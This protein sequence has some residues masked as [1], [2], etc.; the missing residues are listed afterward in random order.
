M[1]DI[2]LQSRNYHANRFCFACIVSEWVWSGYRYMCVN[3]KLLSKK[4]PKTKRKKG[5]CKS[6]T[7]QGARANGLKKWMFLSATIFLVF[8][9][10]ELCSFNLFRYLKFFS[11]AFVTNCGWISKTLFA[12]TIK[13][14]DSILISFACFVQH[15]RDYPLF[16]FSSEGVF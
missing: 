7:W 14:F 5:G 6:A 12:N 11:F 1:F 3:G 13:K 15:F 9:T 8:E 16:F 4:K 2:H 10:Q